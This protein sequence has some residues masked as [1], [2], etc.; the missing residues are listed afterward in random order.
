VAKVRTPTIFIVGDKDPRVPLAQS[1]EMHRALKSLGV[2]TRST[3]RRAS[4]T[5]RRAAPPV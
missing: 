3:S 5:V 1:I 4:R 2:P